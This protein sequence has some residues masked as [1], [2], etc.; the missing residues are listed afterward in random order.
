MQCVCVC[1]Y[2]CMYVCVCV[3]VFVF[4]CAFVALVYGVEVRHNKVDFQVHLIIHIQ[5][6][7]ASQYYGC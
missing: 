1:A 7:R 6:Q 5:I 3:C 2:V 4:V